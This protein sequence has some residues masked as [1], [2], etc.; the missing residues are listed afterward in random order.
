MIERFAY[1]K[2][3]LA[4]ASYVAVILSTAGVIDPSSEERIATG[5]LAVVSTVGI[6]VVDA[7]KALRA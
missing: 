7:I 6:I 2:F 4:T 5:V 1:K 3:G